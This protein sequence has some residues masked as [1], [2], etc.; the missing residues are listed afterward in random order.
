[1]ILNLQILIQ[2]LAMGSLWAMG[3]LATDVILRAMGR[4]HSLGPLVRAERSFVGLDQGEA[5]PCIGLDSSLD[6]LWGRGD[7]GVL[8]SSSNP[9]AGNEGREE[10]GGFF[11][12]HPWRC[13][14]PG[15]SHGASFPSA[16]GPRGERE[17]T[18]GRG[19]LRIPLGSLGD[20]FLFG[21]CPVCLGIL[22]KGEDGYCP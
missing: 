3:A 2:S 17:Y 7:S 19:A 20:R 14:N 8:V 6:G 10:Q 22:A 5:P 13:L 1:M 21:S 9:L 4:V 11:P 16:G 18:P 15:V 12:F